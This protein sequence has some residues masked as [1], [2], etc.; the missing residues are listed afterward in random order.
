[1]ARVKTHCCHIGYSFQLAASVLLYTPSQW[2]YTPSQWQ[3]S[4]YHSPCVPTIRIWEHPVETHYQSKH[5]CQ[6]PDTGLNNSPNCWSVFVQL[7]VNY[8]KYQPNILN[9]LHNGSNTDYGYFV[10][11]QNKFVFNNNKKNSLLLVNN[12]WFICGGA[13][14]KF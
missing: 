6:N 4:T 8:R 13:G 2:L 7:H 11:M 12:T 1:M 14:V 10:N 9:V 5:H 3:D